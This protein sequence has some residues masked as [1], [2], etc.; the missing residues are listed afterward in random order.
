[1]K[2]WVSMSGWAI[3]MGDPLGLVGN[4][5][6]GW[7]LEWRATRMGGLLGQVG[8][9]DRQ[10][11]QDRRVHWDRQVHQNGPAT[12]MGWPPGWAGHWDGLATGM[13]RPPG[14]ADHWD[15]QTT[16]KWGGH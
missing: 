12:W 16:R 1:M 8:H 10:V 4:R 14:W 2:A 9:W 5:E 13:G 7:P 6:M 11:H 3:G 15:G